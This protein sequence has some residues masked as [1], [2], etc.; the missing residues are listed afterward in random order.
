MRREEVA[1]AVAR[2]AAAAKD[3]KEKALLEEAARIVADEAGGEA[4]KAAPTRAYD[5]L[6]R[7]A[8]EA[9]G[10]AVAEEALG[11]PKADESPMEA[12]RRAALEWRYAEFARKLR[13][14]APVATGGALLACEA[15]ALGEG[16][17]D[18][19]AFRLADLAA[20]RPI[21]EVG[22]DVASAT[23]EEIAAETR[24]IE[25]SLPTSFAHELEPWAETLGR[26]VEP[27]NAAA[28]GELRFATAIVVEASAFGTEDETAK[29]AALADLRAREAQARETL[30]LPDDEA[31]ARSTP[32]AAAFEAFGYVDGRTEEEKRKKDMSIALETL[33]NA[34][35]AAKAFDAWKKKL[36]NA[37]TD[38]KEE[39]R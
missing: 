18:L 5:L 4:K 17:L 20:A 30:A 15:T 21:V 22:L 37:G 13:G 7:A 29:E 34:A 6:L 27:E 28:A 11:E 26:A 16:R 2:A 14:V 24:R 39:P 12:A 3:E 1:A 31:I 36:A 32:A 35:R 9:I 33:A 25:A 8:P 23:A 38:E 19:R 10:A